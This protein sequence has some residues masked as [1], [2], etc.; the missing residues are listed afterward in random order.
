MNKRT[1]REYTT[2]EKEWARTKFKTIGSKGK[3]ELLEY[4]AIKTGS[5]LR[6]CSTDRGKGKLLVKQETMTTSSRTRH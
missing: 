6:V 4:L 3:I 2:K 1:S 5:E